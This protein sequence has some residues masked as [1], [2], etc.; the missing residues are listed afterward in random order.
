MAEMNPT[1]SLE[2]RRAVLEA[3]L[4]LLEALEGERSAGLSDTLE[5][6]LERFTGATEVKDSY[7][8]D[9]AFAR[10]HLAMA[11]QRLDDRFLE[12]AKAGLNAA[13]I[14]LSRAA[15]RFGDYKTILEDTS[16]SLADD[17]TVVRDP[18]LAYAVGGGAGLLLGATAT[19]A[20]AVGLS[21]AIHALGFNFL[22]PSENN[23]VPKTVPKKVKQKEKLESDSKTTAPK[24][25]P[26]CSPEDLNSAD[27]ADVKTDQC[28]LEEGGDPLPRSVLRALR[29]VEPTRKSVKADDQHL[30][31]EATQELARWQEDHSLRPTNLGDFLIRTETEASGAVLPLLDQWRKLVADLKQKGDI[32]SVIES[33]FSD[34]LSSYMR[35]NARLTDFLEKMGGNCEAETK[36]ILASL[37]A[38]GV[39]LPEGWQPGIQVFADHLQAVLYNSATGE[40]WNLLTG[41]KR[42]EI[43]APIYDPHLLYLAYLKGKGVDSPITEQELLLIRNPDA[44][45]MAGTV[46]EFQT[47][48]K[49]QFPEGPP[50][51]LGEPPQYAFLRSPNSGGGEGINGGGGWITA[52]NPNSVV[53]EPVEWQALEGALSEDEEQLGFS[54]HE[55]SLIFS[56]H[57][58]VLAYNALPL[59]R[60]ARL[61]FLVEL[62]SQK[63]QEKLASPDGKRL[64]LLLS[65][66]SLFSRFSWREI[67]MADAIFLISSCMIDTLQ[68]IAINAHLTP[69]IGYLDHGA[70]IDE[71]FAWG[72]ELVEGM[73]RKAVPL[74]QELERK[75]ANLAARIEAHP[76]EFILFADRLTN[77]NRKL[78]VQ[79]LRDVGGVNAEQAL[80]KVLGD[81]QKIGIGEELGKPSQVVWL[82]W[83]QDGKD[84]KSWSKPEPPEGVPSDE[85]RLG[86]KGKKDG[87]ELEQDRDPPHQ[88][89][90]AT[91]FDFLFGQEAGKR[92]SPLFSKEFR[93]INRERRYRYDEDFLKVYPYLLKAYPAAAQTVE[94]PYVRMA[95]EKYGS[96]EEQKRPVRKIPPDI[97]AILN[98]ILARRDK[99]VT[100][101]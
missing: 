26:V 65:N 68:A 23:S 40:V 6:W 39:T 56:S 19:M 49:M 63:I 38:A 94:D 88:I 100:S 99:K 17:L 34:Y 43:V 33:L 22:D 95:S 78:F 51:G 9:I 61:A 57:T 92:W 11:K 77:N 5:F 15:A 90:F 45:N 59:E 8:E 3:R 80:D 98:E 4:G 10:A 72:N 101:N 37:F 21:A 7:V 96:V 1:V 93:R 32:Q 91:Y 55:G 97:A 35:D 85:N 86:R 74:L 41:E 44:E 14:Y 87:R 54:I 27:S 60:D 84:P 48:T 50:S 73:V 82:T 28:V 12:G 75:K 89:N 30:I 62:A 24:E 58:A 71:T 64:L 67:G 79:C 81:R 66:P 46:G 47:D 13:D 16:L 83:F 18:A 25:Y 52:N 70:M 2:Q 53:H 76:L 20:T 69:E 36:L 31:A 42:F 29:E